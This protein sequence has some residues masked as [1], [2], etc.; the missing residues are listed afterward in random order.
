MNNVE[1]IQRDATKKS[2]TEK[3]RPKKFSEIKGQ[4]EPITKVK[5]FLENFP[6]K[7]AIVLH[8]PPGIGKT[9]LAHV[10]AKEEE[11]EIFELNASDLRNKERLKSVLRPAVEQKSLFNAKKL[12]LIDE[13][14][15]ISDADWGGIPELISLIILTPCPIILTANDVWKKELS[16]LRKK[17]DLAQFKEINYRMIREVLVEILEKENSYVE[18]KMLTKIAIN[19]RG[20]LR[21]AINDLQTEAEAKSD[22][23]EVGQ[24]NKGTDIFSALRLVFKGK[25]TEET[26]KIFDSVD[27]PIDEIMLWVEENIPAEYQGKE[28]SRAIDLLGKTDK[29]KKRIYRQQYWRF[30]IYENFFLS[31]GV[32]ASKN[33]ERNPTGFTSY[34]RPERILKI[35]LNNQKN[36]KKKTIAQ[37]YPKAMHI[38]QKRALHD[39]PVI[40]NILKNPEVRKELKL[41]EEEIEYLDVGS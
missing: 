4:E 1:I 9:T 26:L 14:D 34:K 7:K 12:I 30:L 41:S 16:M 35:W 8:G 19:A 27:M 40:K 15:G 33:P 37:K 13:V 2:W 21:A 22:S 23:S 18:E 31:Y 38:G 17:A 3:Y 5:I 32:S 24:R 20:D 25:P 28:L 10:A 29:F 6:R 36:E 11:Y 39:F